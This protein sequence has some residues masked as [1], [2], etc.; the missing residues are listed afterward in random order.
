MLAA[1]G[2]AARGLG[3]VAPNP[4]VGCVI[5][6]QDRVVGR[7]WTQPGGRPHAEAEAL[8]RAGAAARGATAYITLEPCA[9]HGKTPP[10]AD[11]LLA[12]GVS[13]CVI[14]TDDP[15][16]RVNGAGMARLRA[17]G[18]TVEEGLCR[19]AAERLNAGFF[20]VVRKGRPLV[21]LKLASSL[22]GR[23]ACQGG[24]SKWIT[25]PLARR[26]GHLLRASHDAVMVGSGTALADDPRLDVRLSG[27]ADAKPLR[28]VLDSRLRLP[29]THDLVTRAKAQ[30]TLVFTATPGAAPESLAAA[31][32]EVAGVASG[33][34]G[35]DVAE[36]MAQLAGHGVT[37]LLVEG[38]GLLAAALLK[39][40]LVDRLVV[41]RAPKI[42]GGDAIPAVGALGFTRVADCPS[43]EPDYR[44]MEGPDGAE[45]YHRA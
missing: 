16:P 21:T 44:G 26:R 12:A 33:P 34:D 13:R 23:I 36:V 19:A 28:V 43:F 11:A 42:I 32:V 9:H 17:A 8:A 1:L 45:W 14:A 5:V 30:A 25:G 31:G 24:D 35:L 39:A 3:L 4:A 38:G 10:C 27:L 15:D 20:S 40:D 29:L 22:D 2:L 6:S 7:G 41:F 37:R 18:V